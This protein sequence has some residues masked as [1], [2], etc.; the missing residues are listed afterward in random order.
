M[1]NSDGLL[2]KYSFVLGYWFGRNEFTERSRCDD[3]G[4]WVPD[5]QRYECIRE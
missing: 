1:L 5:P 4:S 2:F 3:S